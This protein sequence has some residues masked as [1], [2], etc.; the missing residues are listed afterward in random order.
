MGQPSLP[1]L[2]AVQEYLSQVSPEVGRK[3]QEIMEQ[4]PAPIV[5]GEPPGSN[6]LIM[7]SVFVQTLTEM[8]FKTGI[9]AHLGPKT[10]AKMIV[11]IAEEY[12]AHPMKVEWECIE[13][14]E[15]VGAI[16]VTELNRRR[17]ES[18]N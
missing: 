4:H 11:T 17:K 13:A 18:T 3:I 8:A 10:V 7:A 16:P 2:S 12:A 1:Y 15:A 6:I 9:A 14:E 5:P